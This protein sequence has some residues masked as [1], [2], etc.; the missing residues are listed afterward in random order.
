MSTK[1]SHGLCRYRAL[2][3]SIALLAMCAVPTTAAQQT[4]VT[5][6]VL[7]DSSRAIIEGTSAPTSV[8]SFRD[9]YAGVL[10]L[11]DRVENFTLFDQG[12]NEIQVRRIAPGQFE[13]SKP[14]T[15]FR[16]EVSLAPSNRATDSAM[17]SWLNKERGLLMLGDLLPISSGDDERAVS[18]MITFEL[19]DGWGIHSNESQ[20]AQN[21]FDARDISRAVF[22]VGLHLRAS[23][24]IE[25]GMTFRFV[26]DGDWAF[27]D[28]DA[29][30]LV[31]KVLKAHGEVFGAMPAKQGTLILVPFPQTVAASQW[32]AET[33]GWTVTLLMGKSPSK[34]GAL[35]QLSTPLTHELL[36]LWIPN[37]LTLQG[38]YDWFYEGFTI[39]QAA[40]TAVRLDLLT[41]SEFLNSIA[42]AYDA[43]LQDDALSLI[44]ASKRRFTVGQ[45]SVYSKS[46]VVAFVCDLRLRS[47]SRGK[48]S[49]NDVYRRLFQAH[50]SIAT[51]SGTPKTIDGNEAVMNA[52]TAASGSE[53]FVRSFIRNP[54]SIDLAKELAPFGL[55]LETLGLRSHIS[56]NEKLTKQQ[57][58]LLRELGYNESTHAPRSSK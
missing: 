45:T 44:E 39:Y 42:R 13:S 27:A 43:S 49:L 55:K 25:S 15:R 23:Q 9:S 10:G 53:D 11:G 58:E 3:F 47:L 6:R 7:P 17:V 20:I 22:A 21:K 51:R 1:L 34:I 8:W 38:D 18:G 33:R 48:R 32:S 28:H 26:T 30:E 46:Q 56:V 19:P 29:L 40:R 54:N 4:S 2:A 16:Y 14:A 52:L 35:A 50:G 36:H 5:I 24:I 12:G 31:G 37:G 41:F 57:R